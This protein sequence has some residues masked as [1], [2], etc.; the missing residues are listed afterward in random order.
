MNNEKKL[1]INELFG[2]L[3]QV[4][5]QEQIK[6]IE[7][8]ILSL[9]L[10]SDNTSIE[11]LMAEGME[12]MKE[13]QY[14]EALDTFGRVIKMDPL[15]VEGWNKRAIVYYLR[16]EFKRAM[17]D[18][19]RA[20]IIEPRHFAAMSGMANIYRE[21]LAYK[22]ALGVLERMTQ[23]SPHRQTLDEQIRALKEKI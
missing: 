10:H 6:E 1:K 18:I 12:Q 11:G 19:Q 5:D 22:R 23:I 15:Y 21:V 14:T 13:S 16:G 8:T 17:N 4:T 9:W 2:Q 3:K 7:S 20:L